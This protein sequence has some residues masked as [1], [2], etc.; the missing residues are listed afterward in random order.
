MKFSFNQGLGFVIG[1]LTIFLP[2]FIYWQDG[3]GIFGE[4]P[5][6]K[7]FIIAGVGGSVGF[8]LFGGRQR[9]LIG[10]GLGFLAGLGGSGLHVLYTTTFQRQ[11]LWNYESAVVLLIGAGI[12]MGV[13]AKILQRD[14]KERD[15]SPD[16]G[17]PP[18]A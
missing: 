2:P 12:P 5:L 10:S 8:A 13:F 3:G 16:G 18:L 9:W 15:A 1:V 17:Q 7:V 11:T 6:T 4:S 14:K